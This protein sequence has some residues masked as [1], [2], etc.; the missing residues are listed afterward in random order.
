MICVILDN[1]RNGGKCKTTERSLIRGH[2]FKEKFTHKSSWGSSSYWLLSPWIHR[3]CSPSYHYSS[4]ALDPS[5]TQPAMV[6]CILSFPWLS[7]RLGCHSP[8]EYKVKPANTSAQRSRPSKH[9]SWT[10]GQGKCFFWGYITYSNTVFTY[11][12][13][14]RRQ[15]SWGKAQR[16][17]INAKL[18]SPCAG[19]E[20]NSLHIFQVRRDS[21][22]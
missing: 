11:L 2:N 14:S 8:L 22:V 20:L 3:P 16:C 5:L 1:I 6:I 12:S 15:T 18:N 13:L 7:L 9:L 4:L 21:Y 10:P 19:H 17:L